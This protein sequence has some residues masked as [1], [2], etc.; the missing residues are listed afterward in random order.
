MSGDVA[1]GMKEVVSTLLHLTARFL[2][3]RK[4]SDQAK[5]AVQ[6]CGSLLGCLCRVKFNEDITSLLLF[7]YGAAYCER[8]HSLEDVRHGHILR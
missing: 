6:D 1:K 3:P 2:G 5:L 8:Q 7:A 4:L